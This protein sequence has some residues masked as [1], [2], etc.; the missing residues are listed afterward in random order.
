[1]SWKEAA[2]NYGGKKRLVKMAERTAEKTAE[3]KTAER[4]RWKKN[5][6]TGF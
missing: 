4:K 1:M 2:K 3:K 6:G 5:S